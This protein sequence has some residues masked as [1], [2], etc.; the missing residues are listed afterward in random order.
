MH[1]PPRRPPSSHGH[2]G[3]SL[4]A[5]PHTTSSQLVAGH[6]GRTAN[7]EHQRQQQQHIHIVYGPPCDVYA[8]FASSYKPCAPPPTGAQPPPEK[9]SCCQL[10]LQQQQPN[11]KPQVRDTKQGCARYPQVSILGI[12]IR[13]IIA[14][15]DGVAI[16]VV[17]VT[18]RH[19]V[20]NVA[21][22]FFDCT[23]EADKGVLDTPRYLSWE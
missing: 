4:P 3:A 13:S 23:K 10:K 11:H 12:G 9:V 15:S 6:D 20:V 19:C 8:P 17:I 7:A 14:A 18:G 16:V 5:P 22:A 21:A 1:P 2:H